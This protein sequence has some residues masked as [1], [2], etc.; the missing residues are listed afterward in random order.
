MVRVIKLLK[1]LIQVAKTLYLMPEVSRA[2]F[3]EV[4]EC[5]PVS[6]LLFIVLELSSHFLLS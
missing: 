1:Y 2:D 5:D 4:Q 3:S 6:S